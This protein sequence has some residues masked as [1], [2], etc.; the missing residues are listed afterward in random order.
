MSVRGCLGGVAGGFGG[1][2][3]FGKGLGV[4]CAKLLAGGS[5]RYVVSVYSMNMLR[6][7]SM[8]KILT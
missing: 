5:G 3:D 2:C 1:A 6:M 8:G 7:L 4:L